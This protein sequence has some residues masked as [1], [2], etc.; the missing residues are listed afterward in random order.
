VDDDNY[1]KSLIWPIAPINAY[2]CVNPFVNAQ[3]T[4]SGKSFPMQAV[5]GSYTVSNGTASAI[6]GD[7]NVFMGTQLHYMAE[8]AE[9]KFANRAFGS[10]IPNSTYC[11]TMPYLYFKPTNPLPM[12][13]PDDTQLRFRITGG[14]NSDLKEQSIYVTVQTYRLWKILPNSQ[15][16]PIQN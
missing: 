14:D 16:I 9:N 8:V 13:G 1:L 6:T 10:S 15:I 12:L 7:N 5:M 3:M 2:D 11:S 4:Y